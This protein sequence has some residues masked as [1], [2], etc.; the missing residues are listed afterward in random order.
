MKTYIVVVTILLV[1][2]LGITTYIYFL[3]EQEQG[4]KQQQNRPEPPRA[5]I[6]VASVLPKTT[7]FD[8]DK[9]SSIEE[10]VAEHSDKVLTGRYFDPKDLQQNM[11]EMV[12]TIPKNDIGTLEECREK[13][14]NGASCY[15]WQWNPDKTPKEKRC[16][17]VLALDGAL[18]PLEW[19]TIYQGGPALAADL[20]LHEQ[21]KYANYSAEVVRRQTLPPISHCP[22]RLPKVK[23]YTDSLFSSI[24]SAFGF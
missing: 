22:R 17:H 3:P 7:P 14:V 5:T 2:A 9:M 6:H 24:G 1:V 10:T 19:S 16:S 11:C 13:C 21:V 4:P 15:G 12:G 18:F 23:S 20:P 8:Y